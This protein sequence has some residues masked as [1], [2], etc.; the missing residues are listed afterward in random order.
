M[1]KYSGDQSVFLL[2]DIIGRFPEGVWVTDCEDR[3]IFFNRAMEEISGLS[4][5]DALGKKIP[6][7]FVEET[8]GDFIAYYIKAKE[9]L[10]PVE[11]ETT[12]VTPEGRKTI[13]SGWC[14]PRILDHSFNGI[15]CTIKDVTHQKEIEE[16]LQSSQSLLER[17]GHIARIG[18][19]E[20]DTATNEVTW[21]TETYRIHEVPLEEKP[22]LEKAIEFWHPEDRP[23]L[24]KAIAQAI[25]NAT[26][27]DLK[28]RFITAQG[29][30]LRARTICKPVM[31][32][33]KVVKL[34]GTFHDITE[35]ERLFEEL[36]T[37]FSM[38]NALMAI[39]DI[40]TAT[41]LRV[42]PA[43]NEIL[44]YSSEEM[45]EKSYMDFIHPDDI[46]PTRKVIEQ[47]LKK[48]KKVFAFENRYRHKNGAYRWLLWNSNPIVEQGVTYAVA[49]DVTD[50]RI[51]REA[52]Q[53]AQ[54]IESI[55][56]LAGG[57]AH[58][59]NNLLGGIFGNID[60]ALDD[61]ENPEEV[62]TYLSQ[63]LSALDRAKNLTQQLLTFS[64]GGAPQ[65]KVLSLCTLLE[66]S[67]NLSLSGSNVECTI[68]CD[69][70]KDIVMG[71][72]NQ[73]SQVFNNIMLNARQAMPQGGALRIRVT[74]QH[75]GENEYPQLAAG[76]YLIIHTED[77]GCGIPESIQNKIFDPFFTTKSKGSGLGLTTSYSIINRHEGQMEIDSVPEKG[78]IVRIFL[79]SASEIRVSE[80]QNRETRDRMKG[81]VLVMDDEELL[82]NLAQR[83]LQS[84]GFEVICTS[85]G[86][87]AITVCKE[88]TEHGNPFNLALIDL[89][90]PG[91]IGG[92]DVMRE[93][94]KIDDRIAG[95]V[96]S[97]YSDSPVLAN[98]AH[99]GFAAKIE[100]PFRKAALAEVVSTVLQNKYQ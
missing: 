96:A 33:G 30:H 22:P 69:P 100:K 14:I 39:A 35:H 53:N 77:T 3:L 80:K 79:P 61:V 13:Q 2:E 43:F 86:Q 36:E 12:V 70:Q 40:E 28:L 1:T 27:Y 98:P 97:G 75:L 38:S 42:N 6:D 87:E 23:I 90:V 74:H 25:T 9:T 34:L 46:E 95:I 62:R 99:Y 59:F 58:D 7:D 68:Q 47:S 66:Q 44:G 50:L 4:S 92:E 57:I 55:G 83:M 19:W 65:K 5:D 31:R 85:D 16:E 81:R 73:L 64:K 84:L 29:K 51:A 63:S 8:T 71:D 52:L 15:I 76:E 24:E 56:I 41:F 89:T 78:T 48:G 94:C 91:G 26:P 54:K 21:T 11:Y 18:G 60:L 10:E 17:T 72:E 37:I 88:E 49:I 32:D 20:L 93:L 67:K 82:R 45:L